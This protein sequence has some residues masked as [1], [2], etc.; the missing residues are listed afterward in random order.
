[1]FTSRS[2]L[3]FDNRY[4]TFRI[5]NYGK[6]YT[7]YKTYNVKYHPENKT[8]ILAIYVDNQECNNTATNKSLFSTNKIDETTS[9]LN[10]KLIHTYFVEIHYIPEEKKPKLEYIMTELEIIE[11]L[12]KYDFGMKLYDFGIKL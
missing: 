1:M 5:L 9:L 2:S 3:P 11:L 6:P 10:T 8:N 4:K 7:N 12:S